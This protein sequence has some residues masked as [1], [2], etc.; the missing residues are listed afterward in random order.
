MHASKK[1]EDLIKE[2]EGC[3]LE[4]YLCPSKKPTIGYGHTS[5]VHLGEKITQAEAD[6]LL[7]EDLKYYAEGINKYIKVNLN[8]N[9]FDALISFVY[10]VGLGNFLN[11]T[12]LKD[13][14]SQRFNDVPAQFKRWI[15]GNNKKVLPGLVRRR[16]A[17]AKLFT[18]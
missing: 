8:Q 15:Y 2:F 7:Q 11:S 6:K 9:Q 10:N 13:L 17:E 3:H 4:A 18:T 12:L 16:E 1:G 5:G 14:N